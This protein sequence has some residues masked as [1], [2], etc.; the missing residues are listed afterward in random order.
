MTEQNKKVLELMKHIGVVDEK[1]LQERLKKAYY[2]GEPIIT[3]SEYDEL[4]GDKDYVGYT[5]EQNGPWEVLPHRIP[6]GSLEKLKTWEQAQKWLKDKGQ[7]I[8]Q[9][10]LDGLS[11]ELVYEFGELTHAIL[12]G[13]GTEGE[14]ILKNAKNFQY[15]PK[16]L[17][18][19]RTYISVRGEVVISNESFGK[20][21][22]DSQESYSNRRNCVPGI[23]RRYDGK[24]SEYLSFWAYDII[25]SSL[26]SNKDYVE[27]TSETGKLTSLF[28]LGFKIPFSKIEMTEIEYQGYGDIR[29][30]AEEFQMDG[31]V[32]KT[33]DMQHQIALKFEP[34]G[35]RTKVTEY[36]W[37]VGSTGKL[38]PVIWFEPIIIGGTTLKKAS[39]A[40]LKNVEELNAPVGS[41]VEVRKMNDVIP[42]VT[43]V[44]VRPADVNTGLIK[45]LD[46]PT[47][48]PVCGEP[49]IRQGADLYCLN[50]I[51]PVKQEQKCIA[52]YW[53]NPIKGI[54]DSWVKQLMA[55]GVIKTPVD[56]LNV[57]L[58][59]ISSLDG[60]SANK[61]HK[62]V[63][64][65][66]STCN[67]I[68]DNDL[69]KMLYMCPIP[70]VSGKAYDKMVERLVTIND[71]E[72]YLLDDIQ[73]DW[74]D[75]LGRAKGTKANE[76]FEENKEM[77][78]ELT[79]TIRE[80]ANEQ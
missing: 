6:M 9:P 8:W 37:E 25:E 58:E 29:D 10:K 71:F 5:P 17:D 65:L 77:L 56:V 31:L 79:E 50:K 53:A 44:V 2:E 67:M 73:I 39:G 35:E 20:L 30:T 38:V 16:T 7:V 68:V 57:K 42:K 66:R 52:V 24:Y 43:K 48:C 72:L 61:A 4:F 40:S 74:K 78:I 11:I 63:E 59:D 62:I 3:D 51:C 41:V 47:V 14:D 34:N 36:T 54:T 75:I 23:C 21:L 33:N 60:Y 32:I 22:I 45:P 12:R 13:G 70:T 55:K 26:E 18:T 46:I 64:Q 76:F 1:V 80:L 28:H 69:Y 15:V 19:I 27:Y 49:L